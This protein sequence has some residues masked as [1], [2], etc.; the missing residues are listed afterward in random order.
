MRRVSKL[1]A[2]LI[3]TSMLVS[4]ALAGCSQKKENSPEAGK[5]V[6][7]EKASQTPKEKPEISVTVYERGRVPAKEGTIEDNRWTKWMNENAPVKL[8]FVAVPRTEATEKILMLFAS[9]NGPDVVY[10]YSPA[11]RHT[12]FLQRSLLPLDDLI[13]KNSNEYKKEMEKNPSLKK[14]GTESDGKLYYFGKVKEIKPTKTMAIRADWLKKLNLGMPKT[15][16]ELFQVAKAFTEQDPDGNGK[17]DTYG[18]TMAYTGESILE[19][20]FGPSGW[21][22]KDGKWA[23]S[24]DNVKEA[25]T[26]KKRLFD[27]GVMDK[28]YLTDKN[29]QKAKQDFITGK[30]GIWPTADNNL[31]LGE[32]K[33]LKKNIPSA[34][35]FPLNAPKS[36]FGEFNYTMD[37]PVQNVACI[38]ARTKYPEAA[39]QYIDFM[40]KPSTVRALNNGL[41]GV[42]YK[43]DNGKLVVLDQEKLNNEVNWT[44]DYKLLHNEYYDPIEVVQNIT[45][46][47][48]KQWDSFKDLWILSHMDIKR[49]YPDITH[50]EH[51]PQLDKKEGLLW[52]NLDK[53]LSDIYSKYVVGSSGYTLDQAMNDAKEAWKKG[54][55]DSVL[56]W[57]NKWWS[58]NKDKAFLAKD[59]YKVM[60]EQRKIV[61]KR[62]ND[63]KK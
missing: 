31:K 43:I 50:N 12:L 13:K 51:M 54:D 5:E 7:S 59:M 63:K 61:E 60:E 42:H 26:F 9:G 32:F 14:A 10:D 30:L 53:S 56:A 52:T 24:W 23:Y 3:V 27:A 15:T 21:T 38:N 35:V 6:S 16:E 17:K 18:I 55:G 47:I 62:I 57:Y 33:S 39:M 49:E 19:S 44:S 28:D 45:D 8:K 11:T 2:L 1:L 48:E 41:E 37:N 22:I 58:E 46:P 25:L 36:S 29:G 20:M 40:I 34:E 4:S